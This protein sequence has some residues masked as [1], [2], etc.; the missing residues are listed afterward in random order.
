MNSEWTSTKS[1]CFRIVDPGPRLLGNDYF[2]WELSE[3]ALRIPVVRAMNGGALTPAAKV[4]WE[5]SGWSSVNFGGPVVASDAGTSAGGGVST[6]PDERDD[7]NRLRSH[8]AEGE[9][10]S[11]R[12][13]RRTRKSAFYVR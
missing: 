2:V 11:G 3:A 6:S 4:A 10:V 7:R 5:R 9:R 1:V 13:R 12:S 8:D